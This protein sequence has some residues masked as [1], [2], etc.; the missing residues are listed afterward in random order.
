[1]NRT[2]TGLL[3]CARVAAA[4]LRIPARAADG[5]LS[6]LRRGVNEADG[7]LAQRSCASLAERGRVPRRVSY[8]VGEGGTEGGVGS[9]WPQLFM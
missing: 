2:T 9:G 1:M 4:C 8:G 5:V 7:A 3:V 6:R